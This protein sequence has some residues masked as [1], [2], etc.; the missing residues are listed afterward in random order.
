MLWR[1]IEKINS[2]TDVMRGTEL[3]G[4]ILNGGVGEV[5]IVFWGVCG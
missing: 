2:E 1:T 4:D 5:G 3:M